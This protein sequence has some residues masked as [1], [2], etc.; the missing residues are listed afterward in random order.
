MKSLENLG[1][2]FTPEMTNAIKNLIDDGILEPTDRKPVAPQQ[3][4][5]YVDTRILKAPYG[6]ISQAEVKHACQAGLSGAAFGVYLYIVTCCSGRISPSGTEIG[7]GQIKHATGY[8]KATI[9]RACDQLIKLQLIKASNRSANRRA[10]LLCNPYSDMIQ[11]TAG[12]QLLMEADR[13][14]D[15]ARNIKE[16]NKQNSACE[17]AVNNSLL[18]V[19]NSLKSLKSETRKEESL[20]NIATNINTES[21]SNLLI[22]GKADSNNWA[23]KEY[24]VIKPY[25]KKEFDEQLQALNHDNWHELI[26]QERTISEYMI[27][28]HERGDSEVIHFLNTKRIN[29]EKQLINQVLECWQHEPFLI[30]DTLITRRDEK[31]CKLRYWGWAGTQSIKKIAAYIELFVEELSFLHQIIPNPP[32]T[33]EWMNYESFDGDNA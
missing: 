8:S 33:R 3:K 24:K 5:L 19:N 7:G 22:G 10:W 12:E 20:V 15:I 1:R 32:L 14:I 6:V 27:Q 30:A 17:Q 21:N 16:Q 9:Y 23:A 26:N 18:P 4:Y 13:E 25:L 11:D 31:T 28:A 2:H 29:L